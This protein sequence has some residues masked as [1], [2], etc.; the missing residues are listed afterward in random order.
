ML[1]INYNMGN[2]GQFFT[3]D[4]SVQFYYLNLYFANGNFFNYT[5]YTGAGSDLKWISADDEVGND[6]GINQYNADDILSKTVHYK[7]VGPDGKAFTSDDVIN[8]YKD[9][10]TDNYG[11]ILSD[12][13]Y[14]GTGPDGRMVYL[15]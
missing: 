15:R 5:M 3:E 14:D 7:G 2:D 13:V 1:K 10:I 8:Y 12:I 4:D 9:C 6:F 11:N